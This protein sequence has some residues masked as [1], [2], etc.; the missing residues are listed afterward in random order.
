[1]GIASENLAFWGRIWLDWTWLYRWSQQKNKDISELSV[2]CCYKVVQYCTV[3]VAVGAVRVCIRRSAGSFGC[4]RHRHSL[5]AVHGEICRAQTAK[6][7]HREIPVSW[8]VW[9][10]LP[11]LLLVLYFWPCLDRAAMVWACAAKGRWWLGE[12]M[13][14]VWSS[15]PQTKRKTKE[16]LERG[17]GKRL[18]SV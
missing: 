5:L 18:S 8:R 11:T 17:C 12:E 13:H 2:Y 10:E 6:P 14:G 1:M 9:G 3:V 16:D 15:G 4:R 7:H